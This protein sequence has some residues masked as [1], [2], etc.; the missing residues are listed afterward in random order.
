MARRGI[1]RGGSY[2][3][4][5]SGAVLTRFG[6]QNLLGQTRLKVNGRALY[7]KLC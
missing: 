6:P 5:P 1:D 4:K 3:G 2:H 7:L